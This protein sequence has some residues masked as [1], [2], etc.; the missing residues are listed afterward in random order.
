MENFTTVYGPVKSWRYG[1]SLG[2]DP[3]GKTSVCSFNCVYCQLGEIEHKTQARAVYISTEKIIADLQKFAPWDVDIITLSGSG[4]PTLASNLGQ[5]IL[6]I[7]AITDKPILV[8]TNGTLL[9]NEQVRKDLSCADQVSVKLDGLN[10]DLLKRINRPV[11][12]INLMDILTG[13]RKFR[14]EFKGKLGIQTMVLSDWNQ[15]IKTN[16]LQ[17]IKEI[18]PDEIQLNTPTRPKPIYREL[19]GRENHNVTSDRGYPVQHLKCV[20]RDILEKIATEI[21]SKTGIFVKFAG[22]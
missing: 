15:E 6:T 11:A 21:E 19:D 8:L 5:I 9:N 22:G 12:G 7:K 2:I 16:Y 3:I 18:K 1:R 13:L 14:K 20:S 4:E 17:W 10:A